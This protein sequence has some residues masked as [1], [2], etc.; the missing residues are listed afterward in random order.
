MEPVLGAREGYALWA[1]TYARETVVSAL[2]DRAARTLT[3]PLKG[4]TL[5]DVA[6]GT[7]RRSRAVRNAERVVG[8][9]LSLDMLEIEDRPPGRYARINADMRALPLAGDTFDVVWCRLAI[10][11]VAELE[12]VYGE[13]ARVA[14]AGAII[15]VSDFHPE[16]VRAGHDRSFRDRSGVRRV[17]EHHVHERTDH[18]AAAARVALQCEQVL[19]VCVG[20]DVKP[21]YEAANARTRYEAQRG[22]PLVLALRFRK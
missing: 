19:D 21:L 14:R 11:H 10:G 3:P 15:V 18:T 22:L 9:D 20:P 16:A 2:E 1:P 8:A 12:C 17:V 5:L 6:C 7:G 13:L 4:R